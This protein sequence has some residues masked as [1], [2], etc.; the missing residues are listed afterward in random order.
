MQIIFSDH[1]VPKQI[2]KSIF[3]AG[4]SPR[5]LGV[6]DWRHEAI[7]YLKSINYDGTLFI[8]VPEKRFYGSS[9]NKKWSYDDQVDWESAVA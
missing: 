7:K 8:P 9:D 2:V 1:S 4:P 3:L 5:E 6:V